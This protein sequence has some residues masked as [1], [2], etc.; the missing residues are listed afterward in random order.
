MTTEERLSRLEGTYEQV[1]QRLGDLALALNSLRQTVDEHHRE[2]NERFDALREHV[3]SEVGSLREHVDSEVSS[4]RE[5]MAEGTSALREEMREQNH[6]VL[7]LEARMDNRF[8][9]LYLLAGGAWVST[10]GIMV[11]LF[12]GT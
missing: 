4:L 5:E 8:N 7:N 10:V 12:L 6:R 9:N 3:G 11:G 2:T 1:D